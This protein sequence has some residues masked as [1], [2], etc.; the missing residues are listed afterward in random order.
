MI[1]PGDGYLYGTTRSGTVFR[2]RPDGSGFQTLHTFTYADGSAPEAALVAPG[3][4]FLYGT[5]FTGG[6]RDCGV[7]FRLSPD[8]TGFTVLHDFNRMDGANPH[9]TLAAPGDGFLY[10]TENDRVYRLAIPK[11]SPPASPALP[12]H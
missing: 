12:R 5:T 3:D 1:A 6:V 10:G 4:G 11:A 2:L 8:G 7:V 9:G